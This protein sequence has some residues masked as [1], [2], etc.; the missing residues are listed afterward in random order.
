MSANWK[1]RAGPRGYTGRTRSAVTTPGRI[2]KV[3]VGKG[4]KILKHSKV[5]KPIKK[6]RNKVQKVRKA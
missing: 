2:K 3:N 5:A 1:P 6:G 4:A